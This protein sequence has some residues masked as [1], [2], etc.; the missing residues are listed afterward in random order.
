MNGIARYNWQLY[1][2]AANNLSICELSILRLIDPGA[3]S[4]NEATSRARFCMGVEYIY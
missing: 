2:M 4:R 3:F 1:V